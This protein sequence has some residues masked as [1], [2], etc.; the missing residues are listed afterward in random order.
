MYAFYFLNVSILTKL[1]SF[2]C[3]PVAHLRFGTFLKED[4]SRTIST[5]FILEDIPAVA[6]NLQI[7]FIQNT[8]KLFKHQK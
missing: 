5:M 4:H 6:E 8:P 2:L 1:L 7:N 3:I